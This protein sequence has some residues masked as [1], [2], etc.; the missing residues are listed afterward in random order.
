MTKAKDPTIASSI[1]AVAPFD[2]RHT[3]SFD[4]SSTKREA[5]VRPTLRSLLRRIGAALVDRW[6]RRA[7]EQATRYLRTRKDLSDDYR[8]ELER[9]FM[10]Q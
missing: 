4:P 2:L 10:G 7:S 8:N 6:E 1:I 3:D 9:R 5:A